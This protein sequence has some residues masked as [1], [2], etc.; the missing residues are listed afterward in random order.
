MYIGNHN[1]QGSCGFLGLCVIVA[2]FYGYG[3]FTTFC[4]GMIPQGAGGAF[5]K[6]FRHIAATGISSI[7][8]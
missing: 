1:R 8:T 5:A 2:S 7:S 3:G 6:Y 4:I